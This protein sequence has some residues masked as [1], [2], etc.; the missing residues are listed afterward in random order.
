MKNIVYKILWSTIEDFLG[1]WEIPWELKSLLPD[2]SQEENQ[3][4]AKKILRY[5]LEQ[6][7]ITFYMS[8]WGSDELEEI[9]FREAIK[10]IEDEKYWDAPAINELCI[11]IGNTEKGEKFYNDE[12]IEDFIRG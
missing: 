6:N 10:L 4:M 1:L 12:L 7:L 8:K 3:E 9:G 2:K 11:K 5:F